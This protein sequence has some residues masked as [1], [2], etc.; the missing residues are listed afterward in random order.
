M[1]Y[2]EQNKTKE[3]VIKKDSSSQI[4]NFDS[5]LHSVNFPRFGE[6]YL[7]LRYDD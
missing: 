4:E 1:K 5:S 6:V 3:K 7:V 2:F